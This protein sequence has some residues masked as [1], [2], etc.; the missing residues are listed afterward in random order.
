[1]RQWGELGTFDLLAAT[2]SLDTAAKVHDC[3]GRLLADLILQGGRGRSGRQEEGA[4]TTKRTITGIQNRVNDDR[5][6]GTPLRRCVCVGA[7]R[8]DDASPRRLRRAP[9]AAARAPAEVAGPRARA[10]AHPRTRRAKAADQDRGDR[11]VVD[12][13]GGRVLAGR[14]L[15][16]PSRGGAE[17]A[18]AR[19]ADHGA[20]QGHRRR[21]GAADGR[22]LRCRRDR[23]GAGPRAVAGRQQFG[24]A[25]SSDAGRGDPP[26]RRAAEGERHRG[27]PDQSAIRAEDPGQARRRS[28]R[29][30]H[31]GDR[32]RRRG[33][34][35]RPLR[36]DAPLGRGREDGLRAVPVA[37]RPAHER[38]ELRLHRQAAGDRHPRR[39]QAAARDRAVAP[40]DRRS[41][42]ASPIRRGAA[43][44]HL[45][46]RGEQVLAQI[47]RV[48]EPA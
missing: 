13:R 40:S 36:G 19:P 45:V 21:G 34:P 2:K 11:L 1:M 14:D 3:I 42:R 29:R 33:R 6:W 23:G 8:I 41:S 28:G 39:R 20:Q 24:A 26:G 5:G 35:V 43:R 22:A 12:L 18:A 31:H 38:L 46:Q 47:V 9:G 10:R 25:R 44:S 16:E 17:G 15:S 4:T 37:R 32:A 48:L 7:G 27:D 30:R